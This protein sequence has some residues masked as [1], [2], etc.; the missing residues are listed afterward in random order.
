MT[1]RRRRSKFMIVLDIIIKHWRGTIGSLMVIVM[2]FLLIFKKIT[3]ETMAACI[4]ALIAAGY[5][6]KKKDDDE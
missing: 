4:A 1:I 2:V 6:P 5:L 3:V